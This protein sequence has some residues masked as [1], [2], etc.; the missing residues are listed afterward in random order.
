M[1]SRRR[2]LLRAHGRRRRI[3]ASAVPLALCGTL[4]LA[5]SSP[6]PADPSYSSS[7][8]TASADAIAARGT[9]VSSSTETPFDPAD[10]P[11]GTTAETIVYNSIS[12]VTGE[13][14]EVTGALFVPSGPA[15]ASG[16]Q[17]VAYAH[18]TV[19][20]TPGCAPTEAS[21]LS[22]DAG[23]VSYLLEQGYAVAYTDYQGLSS[24]VDAPAHPYLEPRTAAFDV[25]DSVRAARNV[26]PSLST[27]WVAVGT[28]QGGQAA[29]AAN[30]Y[31]ETYGDG[32][33]LVG[34]AALSPALDVSPVVALAGQSSISGG[35]RTVYPMIVEGAA[36]VDPSI[37][38]SD[39]LH[40]VLGEKTPA[41]I[42][43]GPGSGPAKTAA[44]Q[45]ETGDTVPASTEAAERL[46][47]LLQKYSLPKAASAAPIVTFYGT[48]DDIVQP[49][50]TE[51]AL[52]IACGF[53]DTVLRV[54]LQGQGHSVDPGELL[55]TWIADRFAGVP[56][57]S[58]C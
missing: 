32:L 41:L 38:P 1:R 22:G 39:Y 16:R 47:S 57:P 46:T 40:G 30:E 56:A 52:G 29:W 18:G 49:A 17:I 36:T 51:T 35:Q 44:A 6:E 5:C 54:P 31:N 20:I 13:S 3:A 15:P 4:A 48:A 26:D 53:G 28:S 11:D 10:F 14:T 25:I 58:N 2:P 50:W 7:L 55:I 45:P 33:Q 37:V 34:T 24:T 9:L 23:T 8:P 19:G 42:S 21:D 43:C 12:G 27:R